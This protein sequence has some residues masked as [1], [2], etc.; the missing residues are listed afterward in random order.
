MR[1]PAGALASL[2]AETGERHADSMLFLLER[3]TIRQAGGDYQGSADD[4]LRAAAVGER[5]RVASI[6]RSSA[7]MLVNDMAKSFTGAPFEQTLLHT[8]AAKNYLAMGQIDDAAVEA[9]NTVEH[10]SG[11]LD[12]Y[13]DD[14]YS[15]YVA[16]ACL[17]LAGDP[18]I[19]ALEYRRAATLAKPAAIDPSTGRFHGH[20]ATNVPAAHGGSRNTRELVCFAGIGI[21]GPA[22]GAAWRNQR[23]G[24]A[25]YAEVIVN[26]IPAGRSFLLSDT[27]KLQEATRARTAAIKAAKAVVRTGLK[28]AI[29]HAVSEHSEALG[30]LAWLLLMGSET[31]D[32]RRW[33]TLPRWLHAARVTCPAGATDVRVIF[34]RADGTPV[35]EKVL[36]RSRARSAHLTVLFARAL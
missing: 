28:F 15:H 3:A 23:W 4:F 20:A 34:R 21:L 13:P 8:F 25:P 18:D 17:E 10:L 19:A 36:P 29:A 31:E 2:P 16:A 5:L 1:D 7:S 22:E 6:S 12:G 35:E 26:G 9:R 30:A 11:D 14:A 33:E 24:N 32:L 27:M